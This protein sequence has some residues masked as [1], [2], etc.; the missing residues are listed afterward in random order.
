[1]TPVCKRPDPRH[2][3][4]AR[5]A[6]AAILVPEADGGTAQQRAARAAQRRWRLKAL[7]CLRRKS[8]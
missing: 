6:R 2:A 7:A 5:S 8:R 4:A 3:P 1:M